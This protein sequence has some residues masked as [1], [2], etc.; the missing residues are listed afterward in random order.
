MSK[1]APPPLDLESPLSAQAGP[2]YQELLTVTRALRQAARTFDP[3]HDAGRHGR[4]PE[5]ARAVADLLA[6]LH[7]APG[8][9]ESL[10]RWLTE[11][12][13]SGLHAL[14]RRHLDLASSAAAKLEEHVGRPSTL[15]A[16]GHRLTESEYRAAGALGVIFARPRDLDLGEVDDFELF[17][18]LVY[19]DDAWL[20][21]L[22]LSPRPP[23]GSRADESGA[24]L[25]TVGFSVGR[26]PEA[27]RL[28]A[29][30]GE[31]LAFF[32]RFMPHVLVRFQPD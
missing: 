20:G 32:K 17:D 5:L 16:G 1:P 3:A 10:Q 22:N 9:R 8:E 7:L 24:R 12:P 23:R 6:D 18:N 13:P 11:D 29:L 19:E 26:H 4:G 25:V 28:S 31:Q 21:Y 14:G 2:R 30:R 27:C 15:L